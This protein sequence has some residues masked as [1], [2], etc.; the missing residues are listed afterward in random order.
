M[1]QVDSARATLLRVTELYANQPS[2]ADAL[3]LLGDLEQDAGH[4]ATAV[5]WFQRVAA[6]PSP[7]APSGTVSDAFMRLG[8]MAYTAG[9][10]AAAAQT[11]DEYRRRFP[12][13]EAIEQA[14]YWS[15]RAY[16]RVGQDSV[17]RARL[18]ELARSPSLSYYVVLATARLGTPLL[19]AVGG[20]APGGSG[21]H[22]DLLVAGTERIDLLHELGLD[23]AAAEEAAALRWRLGNDEAAL[24]DLAET[25]NARG[26]TSAGIGI[27]WELRRRAGAWNTRLL[28]IVFPFPY[29]D[30]VVAEA[31]AHGLDPYLVAGLI[32]QESNFTPD[33]RSRVG[34]VGLMQVMPGTG[35][36][37]GRSSGIGRVDAAQ[38]EDP[39]LNMRLGTQFVADLL[40]RTQ[41]NVPEMLAAY[42]AGPARLDRWQG[43][44]EAQDPE[45]FAER[46]PFDETRNYVKIVQANAHIYAA[47]YPGLGGGESAPGR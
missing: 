21:D 7:P 33:A 19:N 45:L 4:A 13:G 16:A 43:F 5:G 30:A 20:Q 23:D 41:G 34:A 17:A 38:L 1:D 22:H 44:P 14:T 40:H 2:A 31:G 12:R 6:L 42:N 46:I 10:Y 27:G 32:H 3:F 8:G 9:D 24:Y 25:L 37:L 35:Q 29:R 36:T 15:A 26:L 11:Y 47:L 18:Q 28:H 39:D